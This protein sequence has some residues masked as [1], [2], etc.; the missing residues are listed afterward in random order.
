MR[1]TR[2]RL[3]LAMLAVAFVAGTTWAMV[4]GRVSVESIRIW[5]ESLGSAG[6]LLFVR[7]EAGVDVV[8]VAG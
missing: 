5:L 4:T 8:G 2:R 1:F 7:G 3:A 6:Q